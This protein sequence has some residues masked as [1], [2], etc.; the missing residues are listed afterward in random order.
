[1]AIRLASLFVALGADGAELTKTLGTSQKQVKRWGKDI[2]AIGRKTATVF[3]GVAAGVAASNAILARTFQSN[4][5]YVKSLEGVSATLGDTAAN[6]QAL[7]YAGELQQISQTAVNTGLQRMV[8]RLSEA[9][10]GAGEA[11]GAIA[12]LGL[13]AD[14]LNRLLPT[15]ALQAV[16]D[17]LGQIPNQA[18]RVRLAMKFF[19]SEGV[20]LVQLIG[21]L[22]TA[23]NEL[24]QMN[25]LLTDVDVSRLT[26][27]DAALV[28]MN[29]ALKA[30]GTRFS[31]NISPVVERFAQAIFESAQQG[32]DL[33]KVI[34]GVIRVSVIAA[35]KILVVAGQM[36]N[37]TAA[38]P[39]VVKFG[40]I[41]FML[42]GRRGAALGAVIGSVYEKVESGFKRVRIELFGEEIEKL[43]QR[44]ADINTELEKQQALALKFPGENIFSYSVEKLERELDAAKRQFSELEAAGQK[45]LLPIAEEAVQTSDAM[46]QV[47]DSVL[48]LAA[49]LR[50]SL[51]DIADA[52]GEITLKAPQQITL[53]TVSTNDDN[54]RLRNQ[55]DLQ[56]KSLAEF[57]SFLA[58]RDRQIT[59]ANS[60]IARSM[61]PVI[62]IFGDQQRKWT[63]FTKA[64]A[65]DRFKLL[66]GELA[67]SFSAA[68]A[69][70]KRLFKLN[71]IA[72]YANA[73]VSGGQA[74]ASALATQPFFPTGLA[75]LAVAVA[76]TGSILAGINAQT[77][78]RSGRIDP[79]A[80][81]TGNVA[82]AGGA[83]G[84]SIA[85][86]P[87]DSFNQNV[88]LN[89]YVDPGTPQAD[90]ERAT[91]QAIA[92]AQKSSLIQSDA[93]IETNIIF[94]GA[95]A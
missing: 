67:N 83:G 94:E 53:P 62:K 26:A 15:E 9:A 18:D 59:E 25:A 50:N 80:G 19:D 30:I 6:I 33:E 34:N 40:A 24:E 47:G 54:D 14:R 35:S 68:S 76:K 16:L 8:R 42:L 93:L 77:F 28:K 10:S 1:M 56:N 7:Q 87:E 51:D 64:G 48:R 85:E 82:S 75:M 69:H 23:R 36:I 57:E 41:G 17:R 86:P 39:D 20:Q 78:S 79:G 58:D 84:G 74:M 91:A 49:D 11:R 44:I 2:N 38:N 31:V 4:R 72:A 55:R 29:A 27:A 66:T 13:N 12:E 89:V 43:A 81:A 52:S 63:Q 5:E 90:I 60:S 45:S 37:F 22:T 71:K 95:A 21:N 46:I 32:Q 70:S 3:A 92:R 65:A 88:T 73:V 61:N